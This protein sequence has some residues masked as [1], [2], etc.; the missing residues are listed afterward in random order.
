VSAERETPRPHGPVQTPSS[1]VPLGR[2]AFLG[3][4]AA[5]IA[6]IAVAPRI[7]GVLSDAGSILPAAIRDLAP[8]GGWR[9]YAVA[10]PMPRF[11]PATYRLDVG[12]LVARPQSLRWRD[13]AALPT[14]HQVSTFHCVTGW[15]VDNVRWSGVRSSTLIDLVRPLPSARYVTF[16]SL[17]QPYVDQLSIE[18]FRLADVMLAHGMNGR[19][20]SRAHGAPLRLIIPEMYGY[21]NVKWV[22]S[23][24]FLANPSP[25]YW[26]QRGYDVDAWV[27]RSNGY[28]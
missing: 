16:Q 21:K 28:G 11:D 26:E 25:G 19:P 6:G 4:V 9:I 7:D 22:R 12:G 1:G 15:T 27:G 10:S 2:A 8:A 24:Q 5:G 18:E 20:L 23:L 17:E 13:F 3:A 14:V